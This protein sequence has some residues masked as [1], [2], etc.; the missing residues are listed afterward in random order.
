KKN[1]VG[2]IGV[3]PG[4]QVAAAKVA[5]DDPTDPNFGLVFADSIVCAIDW[6]IGHGY[7]LMSA[8][9]TIDPFTGPID[10]IFCSDQPGRVAVVKIGRQAVLAAARKNIALVAAAGNFFTDLASLTG[11]TPGSTCQVIPVQLPRVIG[12]SAV[13]YTQELAFYSNYGFGA[14]D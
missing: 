12:V 8:S 13:G 6:G 1:G 2:I 7:D 3:A 4:V 9:L 5:V 10:D 11:A 14:V